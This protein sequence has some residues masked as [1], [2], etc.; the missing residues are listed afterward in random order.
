MEVVQIQGEH[1]FHV[2]ETKEDPVDTSNTGET[3]EARIMKRL[4][5]FTSATA[6]V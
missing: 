5:A 6:V 1:F 3:L 2:A 4:A